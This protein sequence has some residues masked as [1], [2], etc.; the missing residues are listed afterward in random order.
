QTQKR[1]Q[2]SLAGVYFVLVAGARFELTTF[3]L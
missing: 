3:R 1:P 2:L